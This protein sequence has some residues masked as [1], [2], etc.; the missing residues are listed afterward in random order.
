MLI[1]PKPHGGYE[2]VVYCIVHSLLH[3][4]FPGHLWH[5]KY[6]KKDVCSLVY[7]EKVTVLPY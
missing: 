6:N 5:I 4:P 7:I 2:L 3:N 1:S